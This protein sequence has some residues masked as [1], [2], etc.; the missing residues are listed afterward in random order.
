MTRK[1]SVN[2]AGTQR[3]AATVTH[4]VV[5]SVA[6]A[7]GSAGARRAGAAVVVA[8]LAMVVAILAQA[9]EVAANRS[10]VASFDNQ[11]VGSAVGAAEIATATIED[12]ADSTTEDLDSLDVIWTSRRDNAGSWDSMPIGNGRIGLNVWVEPDGDLVFYLGTTDSYDNMGELLKLGKITL[13]MTPNPFASSSS[14][15][16]RLR[17][18]N[19]EIEI[20]AE[21]P[22][23]TSVDLRIWVDANHPVVRVKG[24]T[25]ADVDLEVSLFT[26]RDAPKRLTGEEVP[27]VWRNAQSGNWPFQALYR[28]SDTIISDTSVP[29]DSVIWYHRNASSRYHKYLEIEELPAFS[30]SDPLLNRTFGAVIQGRGLQR[31]SPTTY[32]RLAR[33]S[34]RDIDVSIYPHTAQTESVGAWRTGL[35]ASMDA[36]KSESEEERTA[37]HRAWWQDFWDRHWLFVSADGEGSSDAHT[38]SQN[39]AL[40]RFMFAASGRGDDAIHFNGLIFNVDVMKDMAHPMARG[41]VRRGLDADY[42]TWSSAHWFQN[43]RFAYYPMLMAGDFE[44]MHSLFDMYFD[45]LPLARYRTQTYYGHQG[46]YFP[47]TITFW[48]SA[49]PRDYGTDRQGNDPG[50]TRQPH[51]RYHWEGNLEVSIMMLDYWS[52]TQDDEWLTGRALPFVHE[53]MTF[54][55][56]HYRQDDGSIRIAPSQGLET[57]RP[58][59]LGAEVANPTDAV[60]GLHVV[61]D[62]LLALPEELSSE[63]QRAYWADMKSNMPQIPTYVDGGIRRLAA[64]ESHARS[65]NEK[66]NVALYATFPFRVYGVGRQDPELALNSYSARESRK[67]GGWNQQP[68]HAVVAGA[69]A[70][71]K[72]LTVRYFKEKE[73]FGTLSDEAFRFPVFYGPAHDY[74]PNVPQAGNAMIALQNMLVQY[75]DRRIMLFPVWPSDWDVEFKMSLPYATTIQGT[76]KDGRVTELIVTPSERMADVEY[77]AFDPAPSPEVTLTLTV[78]ADR[79][80][81][82]WGEQVP[83]AVSVTDADGNVVEAACDDVTVT[84]HLV[85]GETSTLQG[86]EEGCS[87]SVT[88]VGEPAD[89]AGTELGYRLEANY[90][91]GEGVTASA[92]VL[93]VPRRIQAEHASA[94]NGV[95]VQ[96]RPGEAEGDEYIGGFENGDSFVLPAVDLRG[97]DAIDIRFALSRDQGE[98]KIEVRADSV[99]GALVGEVAVVVTGGWRTWQ[100]ITVD[101]VEDPGG[102]VDLYFVGVNTTGG[103]NGVGNVDWVEFTG[104]GVTVARGEVVW[105]SELTAG[106]HT[107]MSPEASGF[108]H[109]GELGG[110]LSPDYFTHEGTFYEVDFLFH[111][112]K[113][114]W[115]KV[116]PALPQDFTLVVG[117]WSFRGGETM[118]APA[119]GRYWWP[120]TPPDWLS[121]EAMAVSLVLHPGIPLEER[122]QA[123]PAG[124][125]W[126]FPAEHDGVGDVSL[127][128]DFT[129]GVAVT[130]EAL[131]DDILTVSGG[132]VTGVEAVDSAG[133]QWAVTVTPDGWAPITIAIAAD[134]DCDSTGAV[135]TADARRLFNPMELTVPARPGPAPKGARTIAPVATGPTA[136]FV[137]TPASHD[138][139]NPFTVELRFSEEF[140]VSYVDLRDHVFT[141]TA[142]TVTKARRLDRSSNIGWEI[143]V[144]PDSD[145]EVT[146]VLPATHD[147]DAQGALCA[148]DARMLSTEV[149]LTVPGPN[150]S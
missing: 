44:L 99:D 112:A 67:L 48:G 113:G 111:T 129:E 127:R 27:Y 76:L 10:A 139:Q 75:D 45:A 72:R 78:P 68:I 105:E 21:A 83:F 116:R 150:S 106:R 95:R 55:R 71:A 73:I 20:S 60:A 85:S 61:L 43:I 90:A 58:D 102:V 138:G 109:Y 7:A 122:P 23:G 115:L 8:I 59:L 13:S 53:I 84:A 89:A 92:E 41:R 24:T 80:V 133:R 51:K 96:Q 40:S 104:D 25:S 145:A 42:R 57:L 130:A 70:D 11:P 15:S 148:A 135:C 140:S 16:Q 37:A 54:F 1:R 38:V 52:M 88:I 118:F 123:P 121:G 12:A 63:S 141:V 91:D 35:Q 19:G 136:E 126:R 29:T 50:W 74:V 94:R 103:E 87:G 28:D 56:E 39:Y 146:I 125:F 131:R 66:E 14:F 144:Q 77:L 9:H 101:S 36:V 128:I 33:N 69:D 98:A 117:D 81:F 142:G 30:G 2:G 34:T 143:T 108:S 120:S 107:G 137:D 32:N 3:E 26:W 110:I 62:K 65:N 18:R 119:A 47:E 124:Y 31:P 5:G 86:S 22:D 149:T 6:D 114:L 97:I 82:D 100:T 147:C 46:A 49:V 93:L 79:G 4:G 17:L 132:T 64:S 134:L